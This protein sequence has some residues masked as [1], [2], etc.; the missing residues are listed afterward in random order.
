MFLNVS[1]SAATS[2]LYLLTV[3]GESSWYTRQGSPLIKVEGSSVEFGRVI[4]SDDE[5]GKLWG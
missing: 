5:P 3:L 2:P 1:I 4:V